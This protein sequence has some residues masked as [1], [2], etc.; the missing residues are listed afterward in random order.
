MDHFAPGCNRKVCLCE[1]G[2]DEAENRG[3]SCKGR[4]P[5]CIGQSLYQN[6]PGLDKYCPFAKPSKLTRS[7]RPARRHEIGPNLLLAERFAMLRQLFS[8]FHIS[9]R[10]KHKCEL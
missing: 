8:V 3:N 10:G 6:L 1:P 9:F 7:D 2:T 5:Q 4:S